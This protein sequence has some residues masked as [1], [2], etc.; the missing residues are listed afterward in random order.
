MNETGLHTRARCLCGQAKR[1]GHVLCKGCFKQL[2]APL[3]ALLRPRMDLAER[4][5]AWR[6][7][8]RHVRTG[9]QLRAA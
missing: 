5:T 8:V 7:I 9:L 6:A 3:L 4:R 1:A 2:P